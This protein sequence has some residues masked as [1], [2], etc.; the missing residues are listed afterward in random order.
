[1]LKIQSKLNSESESLYE[2]E[3]KRE[4][5]EFKNLELNSSKNVCSALQ[6]KN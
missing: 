1:M 2:L 5:E 4:M 3:N 6:G